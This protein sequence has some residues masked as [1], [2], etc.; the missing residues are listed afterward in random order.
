MK[1]VLTGGVALK[2]VCFSEEFLQ[3]VFEMSSL[4]SVFPL[5]CRALKRWFLDKKKKKSHF[6]ETAMIKTCKWQ[7]TDQMCAAVFDTKNHFPNSKTTNGVSYYIFKKK[8]VKRKRKQ[9]LR[10][11]HGR[12]T[13]KQIRILTRLT[14]TWL[15]DDLFTPEL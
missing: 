5:N 11:Q 7:T 3:T 8:K 13:A 2:A 9:Q 12:T 4:L 14:S 15:V 10:G 6:S 1:N